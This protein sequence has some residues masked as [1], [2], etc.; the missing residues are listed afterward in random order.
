MNKIPMQLP[1]GAVY[2]RKSNPPKEDWERDYR[3]ASEDGYNIFRHWFMWGS[4]E[5]ARGVYDWEDF[6]RQMDLAAQY[7]I[8]TIIA[9]ITTCVPE[10][11]FTQYPEA[12][13]ETQ[14]GHKATSQMGVSSAVGGFYE[15][16][17]L[18]TPVGKELIQSFLTALASRYKDHPAL[19][20]YDV[21]NECN[22]SHS[23]CFCEDTKQAYRA[24]LKKK[25]G[26]IDALRKAWY[27]YSLS[28]WEDV[29]P[30][31]KLELYP[32]CFD[33]LNFRKENAYSHMKW[34]LD[35]L[36]SIDPNCLLTA[37]GTAQSL[38]NMALGGSDEWMAAEHIEVYGLTFVQSRK[39]N[40]PYKQ[41][42][43]V[44]L[45]RSGANGK[46]F[47]HAESAAG[48]LWYQPQVVGRSRED[49]RITEPEDIR[50]W[51]L[52]SL[53]C[54]ARGIICPRWRPLLDGP[55]FGA[56]GGY[57]MDGLPTDRSRMAEKIAHWAND[58]QQ[59]ELL[60][61]QPI[62]G[63]IGIVIVPGTQTATFLL[64]SFGA[65]NHYKDAVMGAYRAFF[66]LGFQPD[67]VHIDQID[68]Y[69]KL[70]LP[71]PIQLGDSEIE[72]L[73]RWVEKGG[74]L[75]SEGC[76]GYFNDLGKVRVGREG[77]KLEQLFGVVQKDVEFTPDLLENEI[78]ELDGRK[79]YAGEYLQDYVVRTASPLAHNADGK[80][81]L[82]SNAFGKG[83]VFLM[84]TSPALGYSCHSD[85]LGQNQFFAWAA[86]AMNLRA[87]AKCSNPYIKARLQKD[88]DKVYL[89]IINSS[90]QTQ[91]GWISLSDSLQ[92]RKAGKIYWAGGQIQSGSYGLEVSLN[93]RDALV[94]QLRKE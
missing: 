33:W 92:D 82:V 53:A 52:T 38:E 69:E 29:Q 27:R 63:E 90:R 20:G 50:Q 64:S 13:C 49:G 79:M 84:G 94:V 67:F 58:P 30:P 15:G 22:Y 9:E 7:G 71:L 10:W 59:K 12:L 77:D 26:D 62:G 19:L 78:L 24:W 60:A 44:D 93:G 1:Y 65:Q 72:K 86:Q 51:N 31:A 46:P 17:C 8:K 83:R 61:A 54:G 89:W 70:Y 91:H 66:D 87:F 4:I 57:G 37:H 5:T 55:L 41:F 6:D 14:E 80:L 36:R 23:Y 11:V 81:L 35:L 88:G 68:R 42:S 2:F 76:P 48:P 39:G 18:D 85:C 34:K 75:F 74:I 56:F 32:E 43:A 45:T 16:V 25:Y 73:T 28:G 21:W 3:Q 40:E 47:W